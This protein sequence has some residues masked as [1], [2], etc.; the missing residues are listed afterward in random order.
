MLPRQRMSSIPRL[1]RSLTTTGR[2]TAAA[3]TSTSASTS[4]VSDI[5][6]NVK[7]IWKGTRTDGGEY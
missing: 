4:R 3:A 6:A 5:E 2:Q 1:A 7:S